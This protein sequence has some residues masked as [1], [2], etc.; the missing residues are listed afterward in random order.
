MLNQAK[1][2]I[3]NVGNEYMRRQLMKSLNT[4]K[5]Y[6]ALIKASKNKK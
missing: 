1:E 5:N 6:D 2:Q 3:Q 4:I